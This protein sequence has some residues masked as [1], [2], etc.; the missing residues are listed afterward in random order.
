MRF[1]TSWE[2][3]PR[4]LKAR[5]MSCQIRFDRTNGPSLIFMAWFVDHSHR[6]TGPRAGK[7]TLI[8]FS[9]PSVAVGPRAHRPEGEARFPPRVGISHR[10]SPSVAIAGLFAVYPEGI[11]RQRD[12]AIGMSLQI[13]LRH[14]L[15]VYFI[16]NSRP[17]GRSDRH[18]HEALHY[19]RKANDSADIFVSAVPRKR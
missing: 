5:W 10:A 12:A 1:S 4:G 6:P 13:R 2:G 18:S 15:I 11:D 14:R 7:L 3:S 16:G 17:P 9:N 8:S 19:P